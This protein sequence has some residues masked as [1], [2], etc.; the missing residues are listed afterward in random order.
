MKKRNKFDISGLADNRVILT[1]A[2]I[3]AFVFPFLG[4]VPIYLIIRNDKKNFFE[5][6]FNIKFIVITS[7]L[8]HLCTS[9]SL[10]IITITDPPDSLKVFLPALPLYLFYYIDVA[11]LIIGSISVLIYKPNFRRAERVASIIKVNHI[12]SIR[13]IQEILGYSD[14]K[15]KKAF[16]YMIFTGMIRA[17]IDFKKQE[18]IFKNSP[19]AKR[20]CVCNNCGAEIVV[21]FGDTLTCEFCGSALDVKKV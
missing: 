12:T 14:K 3:L 4:G 20:L 2:M 8:L 19:W 17:E 21:N 9:L 18:I 7:A 10:T 13:R 6:D 1:I 11:L 16:D 5:T 15:L